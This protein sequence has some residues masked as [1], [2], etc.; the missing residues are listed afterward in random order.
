[1]DSCIFN[2]FLLYLDLKYGLTLYQTSNNTVD[3]FRFQAS[4]YVDASCSFNAIMSYGLYYEL[5]EKV[6]ESRYK[7]KIV[8]STMT[9]SSTF[10]KVF[11][12]IPKI[13][14]DV[15]YPAQ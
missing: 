2:Y 10:L 4:S 1:M 15:E 3:Y 5:G 6:S 8:R 9:L 13:D 12:C 11:T 14:P 7:V